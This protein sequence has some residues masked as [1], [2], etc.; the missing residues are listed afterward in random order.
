MSWSWHAFWLFLH[1]YAAII[2]FGPTFV[3]PLVGP[4]LEK[5]PQHALFGYRIFEV[6]ENRLVVPVALTM[7]I[8]GVGLIATTTIDIVHTA[9][10]LAGVILYVIAILIAL[11]NQ[12]PATAHAIGILEGAHAGEGG[13]E[14]PPA[15]LMAQV[16]RARIGGMILALLL[17]TIVILMVTKPGTTA[18]R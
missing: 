12:V 10:L 15:G 2:A 13:G 3:F 1:I 7:P 11:L 17:I 4:M 18:I 14:G 16:N 8:S 9:W 5:N 6:I